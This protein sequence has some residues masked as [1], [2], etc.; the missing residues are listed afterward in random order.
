MDAGNVS[1]I[2]G[3]GIYTAGDFRSADCVKLLEEADI[4]CT[5]PPF[6]IFNQYIKQ[7]LD[8]RKKFIIIG[9]MTAINNEELFTLIKNNE[10]WTGYKSFGGGMDMIVPNSV[11]DEKKVKKYYVNNEGQYIVNIEGVIW[12]TN[13]DT[14]NRHDGLWHKNGI[15]DHTQ[16][17]KYYEGNEGYYID[18]YNYDAINIEQLEDIPIDYTG[19]LGV[20][21]TYIEKFNPDEIELIGTG[22]MVKKK[23]THTVTESKK[24]ISYVDK[25]GNIVWSTPYTVSER[26]L[27]NGLRL[28]GKDGNP[29][30]TPWSRIIIRIKNP[31]S[32]K[33]DKGY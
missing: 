11:F 33:N 18:Y 29:A 12:Y 15:F 21:I 24:T 31:I 4:V 16:A 26:K 25:E 23:Y 2:Y 22:S 28:K 7:L 32:K 10:L 20:P 3:D 1:T 8:Y 27:G 30:N 19:Y 13:L 14:Q 17:H 9:K 6:S 5:N